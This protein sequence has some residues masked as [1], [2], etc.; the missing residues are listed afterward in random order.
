MDTGCG[1]DPQLPE[2]VTIMIP[3]EKVAKA[4][5]WREGQ[6]PIAA[7]GTTVRRFAGLIASADDSAS[8]LATTQC[9]FDTETG[10]LV[11]ETRLPAGLQAAPM[12]YEV[13]GRQYIVAAVG[14]HGRM[15]TKLGDSTIAWALPARSINRNASIPSRMFRCPI[16]RLRIRR[17]IPFDTLYSAEYKEGD[18]R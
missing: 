14:G 6:K 4:E 12:S 2:P 16:F 3:T 8:T 17:E 11:W 18:N 1:P 10:E 5:P 13:N 9:A 15:D 7:A